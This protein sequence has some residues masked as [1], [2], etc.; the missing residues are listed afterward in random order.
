MIKCLV[1]DDEPNATE[2]IA[3][4]IASTPSLELVATCNQSRKAVDI[5]STE[6]IDLLFLDIRMP[7]MNGFELLQ[8]LQD[9]PQVII[10]TAHVEYAIF[11]Y[12]FNVLDY[13]LKPLS[14]EDFQKSVAK[15]KPKDA[16]TK[17]DLLGDSFYIRDEYKLIKIRLTDILFIES[18]GKYVHLHTR[19]REY[20]FRKKLSDIEA[21]LRS[22]DFLRVHKSYIVYL[23]AVDAIEGN[24]IQIRS[25]KIPI[26]KSYKETFYR[27][28]DLI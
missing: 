6:Q 25:H 24:R 28:L 1:V 19:E 5:L 4:Y 3:A 9:P 27:S 10:I 11:G 16:Q 23:D 22:K 14:L 18:Y 17:P 7:E 8:E 15:F 13:L 12:Q 20:V 2:L 26:G 21:R